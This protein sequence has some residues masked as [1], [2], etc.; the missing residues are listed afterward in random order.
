MVQW[1]RLP[2]HAGDAGWISGQGTKTSHALGELSP[3]ATTKIQHRQINTYSFLSFS[4]LYWYELSFFPRSLGY[5]RQVS[6]DL[7]TKDRVSMPTPPPAHSPQAFCSIISN[8]SPLYSRSSKGRGEA[9][10]ALAKMS[11]TPPIHHTQ[12]LAHQAKSCLTLCNSMDCSL[13]GSSVHGIFQPRI[14]EW[15]VI[16]FSRD[17]PKHT[18]L[19]TFWTQR[20]RMPPELCHSG[21]VS[22][23]SWI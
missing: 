19:L 2:C 7:F 10:C 8:S 5:N 12:P 9:G 22:H 20:S 21:F 17:L 3:W 18:N 11:Q 4:P 15:V 1:L 13:Q 14:S 6:S 16:P 23:L